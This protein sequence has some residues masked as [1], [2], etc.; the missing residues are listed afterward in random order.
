MYLNRRLFAWLLAEWSGFGENPGKLFTDLQDVSR[1]ELVEEFVQTMRRSGVKQ[2]YV[3]R[4]L[5]KDGY[6]CATVSG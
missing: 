1:A 2:E 6:S 3:D 5:A 4:V